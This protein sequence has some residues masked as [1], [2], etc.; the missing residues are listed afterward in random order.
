V[1]G[2]EHPETSGHLALDPLGRRVRVAVD[3]AVVPAPPA[4]RLAVGGAPVVLG[5]RLVERADVVVGGGGGCFRIVCDLFLGSRVVFFVL[6]AI[7]PPSMDARSMPSSGSSHPSP[8]F[9]AD[10]S[11]HASSSSPRPSF[12]P[13][14]VASSQF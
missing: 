1:R 12:Q 9:V 13:S 3:V 4:V 6:S 10:G 7:A 2:P 8:S 5:S 11:F 14:P